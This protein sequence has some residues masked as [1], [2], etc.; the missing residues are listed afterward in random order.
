MPGIF[1]LPA[2]KLSTERLWRL[3]H[4][5]R[6]SAVRV[7]PRPSAS[8]GCSLKSF[9][10]E[11]TSGTFTGTPREVPPGSGT[12]G[13]DVW[14]EGPFAQSGVLPTRQRI[15]FQR[16]AGWERLAIRRAVPIVCPSHW[17]G[18]LFPEPGGSSPWLDP[19]K[20]QTWEHSCEINWSASC[21]EFSCSKKKKGRCRKTTASYDLILL[22]IPGYVSVSLLVP[23]FFLLTFI[24]NSASLKRKQISTL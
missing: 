6:K 22:K 2:S 14:R 3:R 24:L 9:R 15:C 13:M 20:C 18:C 19:D 12:G 4:T 7:E 16:D 8:T 5:P 10:K 11:N 1:N 17:V 21:V 23:D